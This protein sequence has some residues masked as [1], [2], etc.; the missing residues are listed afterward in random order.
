MNQSDCCYQL[1]RNV[2][3]K[4]GFGTEI[5]E[6]DDS[7]Q[8]A[9][10]LVSAIGLGPDTSRLADFTWLPRDFVEAIRQR[11]LRAELWTEVDVFYS[12]WFGAGKMM[13]LDRFSLDV[14]VAEGLLLRQWDEGAGRYRYCATDALNGIDPQQNIN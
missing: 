9:I 2:L 1:V 11:M 6:A 3:S 12:H 7:Y 13:H 8:T 14:M 5:D 10:V 4:M